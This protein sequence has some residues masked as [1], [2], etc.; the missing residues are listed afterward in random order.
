M[1]MASLAA[2]SLSEDVCRYMS[3]FLGVIT[4]Y[5]I[6]TTAFDFNVSYGILILKFQDK[7][8]IRMLSSGGLHPDEAEADDY[9]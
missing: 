4:G 2:M 9:C 6:M 3:I 1:E 8:L 7:D 5:I